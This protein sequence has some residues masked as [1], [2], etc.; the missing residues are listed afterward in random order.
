[1]DIE[2]VA[3]GIGVPTWR[4]H[5]WS[6][7]IRGIIAILFG[8]LAL[9]WPGLTLGVLLVLFG[10]FAFAD[11]I[12]SIISAFGSPEGRQRWVLLLLTGLA[13][14][15]AGIV[16]F[17]YP[18]LTVVVLLYIIATWAIVVGILHIVTALSKSGEV[19]PRWLWG[20]SGF[21]SVLFGILLY[22]EP[23]VGIFAVV[24]LIGF[25]ALIFGFTLIILGLHLRGFG[26][27]LRGAL[28][29]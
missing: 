27:Q 8:I 2:D 25:Y 6:V 29:H 16:T 19:A 11:G 1:M 23:V 12:I 28:Q 14:I 5:W 13:G 9:V 7:V 3:G 15:A 20:L 4:L 24:W 26:Q 18:G 17:T 10:I 22:A 21:F